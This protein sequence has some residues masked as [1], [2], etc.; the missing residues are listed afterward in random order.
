MVIKLPKYMMFLW[1]RMFNVLHYI[2]VSHNIFLYY[3]DHK[4]KEDIIRPFPPDLNHSK[5]DSIID[6]LKV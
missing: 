6:T 5:V 2:Y 3:V 4:I 1:V